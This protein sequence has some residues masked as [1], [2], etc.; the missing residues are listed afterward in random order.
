VDTAPAQAAATADENAPHID[1]IC[2]ETFAPYIEVRPHLAWL[3]IARHL[4]VPRLILH[5]C[6]STWRDKKTRL[7]WLETAP[8]IDLENPPPTKVKA[9]SDHPVR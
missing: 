2:T 7:T 8:L 5:L 4:A 6:A 3:T 1:L 9:R